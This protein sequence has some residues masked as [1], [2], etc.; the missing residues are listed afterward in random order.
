MSMHINE[1]I[2]YPCTLCLHLYMSNKR[3]YH[4]M[5][6]RISEKIDSNQ[7]YQNVFFIYLLQLLSPVF[8][9]RP[10]KGYKIV[11]IIFTFVMPRFLCDILLLK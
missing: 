4:A 8:Q 3:I 6:Q 9:K 11:N 2:I 7:L 1:K 10:K 5:K